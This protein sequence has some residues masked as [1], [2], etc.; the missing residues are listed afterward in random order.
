[1]V[2]AGEGG[3]RGTARTDPRLRA[4]GE[5]WQ[6]FLHRRLRWKMACERTIFFT[7]G[8]AERSSVFSDEEVFEM[9]I[10]DAPAALG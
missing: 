3:R 4:L 2:A 10:R 6:D 9:A 7:P 5:R 1:M 8:E